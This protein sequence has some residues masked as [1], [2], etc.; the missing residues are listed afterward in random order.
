[1]NVDTSFLEFIQRELL[2]SVCVFYNRLLISLRVCLP[3][4][5]DDITWGMTKPE[6]DVETIWLS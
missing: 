4:S 3:A 6:T 5:G 1:M 2:T